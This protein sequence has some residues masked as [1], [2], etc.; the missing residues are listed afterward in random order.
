MSMDR[1]ELLK[2]CILENAPVKYTEVVVDENTDLV[3]DLGY[4]SLTFIKLI[5]D[6]ERKFGYNFNEEEL[7]SNNFTYEYF[8]KELCKGKLND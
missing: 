5:I 2:N 8:F 3:G 4:D 6:L 7:L 1:I